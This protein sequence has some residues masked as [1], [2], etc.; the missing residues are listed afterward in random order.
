MNKPFFAIAGLLI[1]IGVPSG[2]MAAPLNE[3][4]EAEGIYHGISESGLTGLGYTVSPYTLGT[5]IS[6]TVNGIAQPTAGGTIV[7][8][9]PSATIGLGKS[10]ELAA[11]TALVTAPGYSE[12]GDTEV[13]AKYK[14]RDLGE[15][16]PAMAIAATVIL[17]TAS[18]VTAADVNNISGRIMVI[19]G[20]E[21]QVTDNAIVGLYFNYS[22]NII[23]PGAAT[24]YSYQV[25]DFGLMVPISDDKR[26]QGMF[27]AHVPYLK[28]GVTT[29]LGG[30][31]KTYRVGL[32]YAGRF[33]KLTAGLETGWSSTVLT[34]GATF[35]L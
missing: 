31:Q 8:A 18:N 32:R 25:A 29:M 6:A 9:E 4:F 16:M 20:G 24:Q 27:E 17:P 22:E 34:A 14:F 12:V 3:T 13:S 21:V 2:A 10:I 33:L 23:D 7:I 1:A 28:P 30:P 5:G 26:L 35:E 11:R 19:A 15:T